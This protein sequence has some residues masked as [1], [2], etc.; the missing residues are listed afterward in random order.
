M[1]ILVVEDSERV[2]RSLVLLISQLCGN[3][4]IVEYDNIAEAKE[5]LNYNRFD[6]AIF[7]LNLPDGSGI[8][9][10]EHAKKVEETTVIIF[11]NT[12]SDYIRSKCK[13]LGADYFFDKSTEFENLINTLQD[14]QATV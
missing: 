1:K 11:S 4:E 14:L 2:R 9:L 10:I 7:D 8:G 12:N 13:T 5:T 6:L 3:C